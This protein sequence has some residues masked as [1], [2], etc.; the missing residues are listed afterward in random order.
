[1]PPQIAAVIG[2]LYPFLSGNFSFVNYSKASRFFPQ[3]NE[4]KWCP[5]PGGPLLVPLSDAVGRCIYFTGD[6]DRKI[7]R[8][9]KTLLSPGEVAM[10]VGANLGVVTLTMSKVVGPTGHV[11]SFEPNPMICSLLQQ[12]IDGRNV[13]LHRCGLGSEE[14]TL[15][16]HIP[17]DNRGA[18]SFIQNTNRDVVKCPIRRLDNVVSERQIDKISLIKI[19]VEGFENEVL[20]GAETVL[21]SM[22]PYII[23]ETNSGDDRPL[24]TLAGHDYRIFSIKKTLFSLSLI[25]SEGSHD[26]LAMPRERRSPLF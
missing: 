10:D 21:Q 13:S 4:I 2:R 5:S 12:S 9:C 14:T 11:H 7:T 19:D 22:R 17:T 26:V 8:L 1:M 16:L 23:M 20:L 3:S 6:Y 15:P 25:E 18:A 24:R